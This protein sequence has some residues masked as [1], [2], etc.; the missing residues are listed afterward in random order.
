MGRNFLKKI[1]EFFLELKL[2]ERKH[3]IIRPNM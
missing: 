2:L 3:E 1:Q